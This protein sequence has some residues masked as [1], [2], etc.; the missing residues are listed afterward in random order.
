MTC[1]S[2]QCTLPWHLATPPVLR[3]EAVP[4]QPSPRSLW[5]QS[6]SSMEGW[7][8]GYDVWFGS[9]KCIC[10]SWRVW[11]GNVFSNPRPME[12]LINNCGAFFLKYV[13]AL[14][15]CGSPVFTLGNMLKQP[16]L[17]GPMFNPESKI[18]TIYI[19]V[20]ARLISNHCT[21]SSEIHLSSFIH[22]SR[23]Q[24]H[25]SIQLHDKPWRGPFGASRSAAFGFL[26]ARL[27]WHLVSPRV[28]Q[29][30]LR[31]R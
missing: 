18:S 8:W 23:V 26:D 17:S 21:Y 31:R 20:C 3:V 16:H 15:D 29:K 10:Y 12:P 27:V 4:L 28:A 25:T 13:L 1:I 19:Y 30:R 7:P 5:P 6:L 2:C 9:R 14:V 24:L 11:R 22:M